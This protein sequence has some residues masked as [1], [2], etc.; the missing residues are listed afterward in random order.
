MPGVFV[1]LYDPEQK[2]QLEVTLTDEQ[3]RYK[4][5][6]EDGKWLATAYQDGYKMADSQ[7]E[8]ASSVQKFA[9]II[10]KNGRTNMDIGIGK[11]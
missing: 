4:F 6:T 2:R 3:G 9:W 10:I 11:G 5:L 7:D 8:V 1:R